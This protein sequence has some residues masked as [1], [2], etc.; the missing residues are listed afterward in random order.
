MGP[1]KHLGLGDSNIE[2]LRAVSWF[3][4]V[5]WLAALISVRGTDIARRGSRSTVGGE[6][7]GR[8]VRGGRGVDGIRPPLDR[9]RTKSNLLLIL[10]KN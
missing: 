6:F 4:Y 8:R 5:A 3:S 2:R 9:D 1:I 10:K 7:V